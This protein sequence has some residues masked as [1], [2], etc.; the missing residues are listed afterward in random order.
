MVIVNNYFHSDRI[1]I[2]SDLHIGVHQN[3]RFWHNIAYEWAQWIISDLKSKQITDVVFCGD[4]FHTR[5]E[6]SVDTIHFGTKLLEL[7]SDFKL[8]L[9]TGNHDC[10]LK[11]S[12]E[13]NSIAPFKKWDNVN[14]IDKLVQVD[15]HGKSFNFVPWGVKC[16]DIAKADVTFGHFE[17]NFFKMNSFYICDHGIDAE[18]IL[19]KSPLVISG[20]FHLRDERFFNNRTVLYVGNPFQMDFND[21][22]TVKGYYIMNLNDLKYT[23]FE[24]ATSPQHHNIFLSKLVEAGTFTNNIRQLFKSNLIKLKIDC[25]I[26]PEDIDILLSKIKLLQPCQLTVDYDSSISSYDTENERKDLSGIDVEQA[27]RE[28]I[29]LMN[30]N[31]KQEVIEYTLDL[32][33][34]VKK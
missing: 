14:V 29:D 4:F 28:F 32:Y 20:H 19:V 2:F 24:N 9:I 8:T 6:I 15:S 34:K 33:K 25:R 12:S 22:D 17:I 16:E 7:F 21:A 1:A 31:N 18:D 23:F 10:Y 3:S 27:M 5:D 11:D 26:S 30:I 13:I